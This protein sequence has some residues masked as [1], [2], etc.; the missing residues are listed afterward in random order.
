MIIGKWA[1]RTVIYT[2]WILLLLLAISLAQSAS[3]AAASS[4]DNL[5]PMLMAV[6]SEEE[7]RALL[8]SHRHLVTGKL[9]D[10][11]IEEA[12]KSYDTND[13][14]RSLM[15]YS[16]ARQSAEALND[17]VRLAKTLSKIGFAYLGAGDYKR[18]RVC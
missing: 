7:S 9:W 4:D 18:A 11:L 3:S 8:T 5:F 6:K 14:S 15:I 12:D 17:K 16:I 2:G 10:R 1:I 13:S